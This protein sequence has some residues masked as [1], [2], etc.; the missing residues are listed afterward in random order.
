MGRKARLGVMILSRLDPTIYSII[1]TIVIQGLRLSQDIPRGALPKHGV[2]MLTFP[3]GKVYIGCSA[4]TRG[5]SCIRDRIRSYQTLKCPYQHRLRHAL[6]EH[7]HSEIIITILLISE[8]PLVTLAAESDF[9]SFH[10]SQS[11]D[12]GH[13]I[14]P[15]GVASRLGIPV[16]DE[17][18]RKRS[19]SLRGKKLSE[20]TKQKLSE[21]HKGKTTA[22]E[23]IAK[24]QAAMA[25]RLAAGIQRKRPPPIT[26]E[27]RARLRAAHLGKKRPEWIIK[28]IQEGRLLARLA[29]AAKTPSNQEMSSAP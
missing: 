12:H 4:A 24:I 1:H 20:S 14:L 17:T 26:E 6:S 15:G 25:R 23:T 9:I 13:N 29:R 21:A 3:D 8:D 19:I 28:R 27:T 2:Y 10:R 5:R 11:P 7:P 16:S 18:R 22:P